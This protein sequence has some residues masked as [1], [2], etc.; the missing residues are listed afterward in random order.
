MTLDDLLRLAHSA[1]RAAA[2]AYQGHAASVRD[3]AE[4]AH[5]ARIEREEWAHRASIARMLTRR[6]L[7]PSR[8][9]EWQY[10]CI[11]RVISLSCHVLGRFIPMYF[12]GRLES[13]NVNEYLLLI[14]LTRGTALADEHPCI[15][16]MA[17]VE[18]EHELYFLACV[19]DHRLMPLFQALFGWGPGR[20]RN[21]M[22]EPVLPA[23][24]TAG[25][26]KLG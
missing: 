19:A 26:K 17:R 5:I 3:P 20:S 22:A 9:R 2:F 14:E 16:E 15:L 12:A 6:G 8:W 10:A 1:E 7:A 25:D 24:Q 21:R 18:K 23:C 13:G 11:G 4:R